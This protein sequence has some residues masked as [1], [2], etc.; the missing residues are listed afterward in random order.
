MT[1]FLLLMMQATADIVVT[2]K[3]LEE[4][5]AQCARGGCTP[6]RDAQA[7]IALAEARFRTGAYLDAKKLLAGAIA[8]NKA[9]AASDPKPVAAIYEAYAT[10]ALHE[11]NQFDYRRA[12]ASQV[13]TL[14]DNLPATDSS[15]LAATTA[16]GDMWL[17][18]GDSTQ[19]DAT[20]RTSESEALRSGNARGAMLAGMK[21][22][23]LAAALKRPKDARAKLD[24]L[25]RRPI[26]QEPGFGNALRV[27]RLRLAAQEAEGDELNSLIRSLGQ[28]Q[29][30]AP[31]L[32][33]APPYE[34]DAAAALEEA[35]AR[36]RRYGDPDPVPLRAIDLDAIQW[37]D[38]G[39]WIRPDG[40]TAQAELLRSSKR[41]PW[42]D[43]AL[44]Q[45]AQRRYSAHAD[46]GTGEGFYKVERL[47]RRSKYD[48][49]IGSVI[50]RR[51]AVG[52]F[53]TLD[54]TDEGSGT[55]PKG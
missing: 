12:V 35:R 47:T 11:G 31:V 13:R 5:H 20:Y 29:D 48:I 42:T 46:A 50:S 40:T 36:A 7:S 51:V 30:A 34:L 27:L 18:I 3:R 28:N 16:L 41:N 26:A 14:R 8:R 25:G 2:G 21:R 32:L 6:L 4:A 55:T 49:P 33:K 1:L 52:G 17:K 53:E 23:W 15:V 10:V 37:A 24:E 44:R 22:A 9:K 45:I 19:A 54:L 39:F 43:L 38:F